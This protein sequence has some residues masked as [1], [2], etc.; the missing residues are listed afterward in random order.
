MTKPL[1]A[2]LA[3]GVGAAG[4]VKA[5]LA[6]SNRSGPGVD[7]DDARQVAVGYTYALSKR[8]TLYGA[9]SRITNYGNAAYVTADSS[10]A[11][12]PGAEAFGV[13]MGINHASPLS[14]ARASLRAA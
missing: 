13:Q 6:R 5:S 1:L 8:T 7:A 4:H 12:V 10:P 2:I 14:G 3:Y 9:Y 11:G